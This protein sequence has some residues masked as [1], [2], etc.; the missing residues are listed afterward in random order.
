M[1]GKCYIDITDRGFFLHL[2]TIVNLP[3]VFSPEN[4]PA[5][6]YYS[7]LYKTINENKRSSMTETEQNS[8]YRDIA[9]GTAI[10]GGTQ[11][12]SMLANIAKGKLSAIIIGAYGLGISAHLTSTFTPI[13]QIFT[14]GLNISGIQAISSIEDERERAEYVKCFRRLIQLLAAMATLSTAISAWWL[15]RLTFGTTEHWPWFVIIAVAVFFFMKA[16]GETTILQGYRHIKS[17]ATCNMTVPLSG[18]VIAIPMYWLWGVKGIAPSIAALALLSWAVAKHF[19]RR[20]NMEDVN[21][22]WRETLKR[23]KKML[24]LGASIM[25]S[26]AAGSLSTYA[27]N[28]SISS[29]G[30]ETDVGFYQSSM[31]IT[32]QC[33]AMVFAA[34][35]TDYFPHL[36]SIVDNRHKAKELITKEGEITMLIIAP[37]ILMLITLSPLAVRVLL[38]KEFDA[39][40]FLLRAMSVC[41]LAR[42]LCFPLDYICLAKGD[43]KFFLIVEGGWG[44]VKNVA[45]VIC[46]FMSGGINGIGIALLIGAAIDITVSIG[47]NQWK[48][49]ISYGTAYYKMASLLATAVFAC[50]AS[51]FIA[52][53]IVSYILMGT[54]TITTSIFAYRQMDRRI[55]IKNL[56]KA[57]IKRKYRSK[58]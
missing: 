33:T 9:K 1:Q 38:T 52:S 28:T 43:N 8:S 57:R 18:L 58:G 10:F 6:R 14:C 36:S 34:M 12:V 11:L 37:I 47:L 46:G 22:P 19:T 4:I 48:Y 50:F 17:L 25:A 24:T 5:E 32:L 41:L 16:S 44:N 26:T 42:A 55:D 51:S 53:D 45:L 29:I 7:Y 27:I 40:I 15:S 31:S 49:K 3:T 21:Q 20:L 13:Q 39:I 56:V 30:T 54:I 23:G 2:L 35:A